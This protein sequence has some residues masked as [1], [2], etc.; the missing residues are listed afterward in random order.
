[1]TQKYK[2]STAVSALFCEVIMREREIV[3]VKDGRRV[4]RF[5]SAVDGRKIKR[6]KIITVDDKDAIIRVA[7]GKSFEFFVPIV[8]IIEERKNDKPILKI[9]IQK[10]SVFD[11]I[12]V[13]EK[14]PEVEI[15]EPGCRCVIL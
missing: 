1:M 10:P 4:S 13:I 3:I 11:G 15:K 12:G 7:M 9:K 2:T 8:E 6:G 5:R 14:P